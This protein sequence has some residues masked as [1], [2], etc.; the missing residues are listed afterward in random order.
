MKRKTDKTKQ[1][2]AT[3]PAP[4]GKRVVRSCEMVMPDE[5]LTDECA[6]PQ[7]GKGGIKCG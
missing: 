5:Y 2:K 3:R 4:K 6:K 1:M 7:A